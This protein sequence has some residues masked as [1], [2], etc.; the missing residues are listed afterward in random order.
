MKNKTEVVT[1]EDVKELQFYAGQTNNIVIRNNTLKNKSTNETL[2]W[3]ECI[4]SALN[5]DEHVFQYFF[6]ANLGV[7][8]EEAVMVDYDCP[9]K[10]LIPD[11]RQQYNK[12]LQKLI[13][14]AMTGPAFFEKLQT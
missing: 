8:I 9:G 4:Y 3:N 11:I 2:K 7:N 1:F 6:K 13:A 14:V 10:I 5:E 12:K